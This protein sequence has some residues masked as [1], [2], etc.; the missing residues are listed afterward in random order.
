MSTPTELRVFVSSTFRDL[1]DEREYL[2]KKVFPE[3]R[4]LCRERGVMFTEIDLRWG[5]TDEQASLGQVVRIC[6]D[7]IDRCRP[8][9]IGIIGSRYGWT[10]EDGEIVKDA[11]LLRLHP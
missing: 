5:L 10:P 6:L 4:A 9:F 7:E 2:V 1:R 11:E 3:I 8:Y